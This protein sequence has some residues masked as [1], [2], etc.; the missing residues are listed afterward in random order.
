MI[1]YKKKKKNI[2]AEDWKSWIINCLRHGHPTGLTN[3]PLN[4]ISL[5]NHYNKLKRLA[6]Y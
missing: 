3:K 5:L 6:L 2:G 4:F 1:S